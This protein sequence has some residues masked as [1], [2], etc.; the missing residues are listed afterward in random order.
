MRAT[1]DRWQG[2]LEDQAYVL[3][4]LGRVTDA[5][6]AVAVAR[7]LAD[8]DGDVRRIPFLRAL[9]ERSLEVAGE[10]ATGRLSAETASRAPRAPAAPARGG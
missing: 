2:R 4:A 1:R 7:A 8:P 10:V 6:A 5:A 3:L 9:V